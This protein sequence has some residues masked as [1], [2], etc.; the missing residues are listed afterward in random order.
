MFQQQHFILR[1]FVADGTEL[2]H[3]MAQRIHGI[4]RPRVNRHDDSLIEQC[5]CLPMEKIEMK[6]LSLLSLCP[7]HHYPL[8]QLLGKEDGYQPTCRVSI[9]TRGIFFSAGMKRCRVESLR[10]E[11]AKMPQYWRQF[12]LIMP[13][14]RPVGTSLES[15]DLAS[16]EDGNSNYRIL[17]N[18][19]PGRF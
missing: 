18:K 6:S 7:Y 5:G 1:F 12:R 14:T 9:R 11:G 19:R 2:S 17:P 4:A 3:E 13:T 8:Q 10:A 16:V 15:E